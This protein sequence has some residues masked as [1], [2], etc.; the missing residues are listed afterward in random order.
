MTVRD[1]VI[2]NNANQVGGL[3][4]V[5][6]GSTVKRIAIENI[7][8]TADNTIGG[9]AGQFDGNL[10]EDCFVT[11]RIEGKIRHQMGART[12]G[13]TGWMGGGTIRNCYVKV[14]IAAPDAT[15]N[16]GIIGGPA[17]GSVTIENSVSLST[18]VNANRIAGWDVLGGSSNVYELESSDSRSSRNAGN[19]TR[20]LS[21]SDIRAGEKAFYTDDLGWSGEVW[22]FAGVPAGGTPV[23]RK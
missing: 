17:N 22:D 7:S 3:A 11:G 4:G 10:I 12:G 21:V 1:L 20:I 19:E 13:I 18:G 15:G 2:N 5:I 14:E 23:L 16:G 6:T 9:V 8:L